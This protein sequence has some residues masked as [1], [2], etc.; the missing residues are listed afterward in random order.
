MTRDISASAISLEPTLP[1]IF[2][3]CSTDDSYRL[4]ADLRLLKSSD[5]SRPFA[6]VRP[7]RKQPFIQPR[8][9]VSIGTPLTG[10]LFV[11]A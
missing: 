3:T 11:G 4:I 6:A 5:G 7:F 9:E 1:E 2:K 8:G 10:Y